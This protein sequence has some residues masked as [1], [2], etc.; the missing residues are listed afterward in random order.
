MAAL[1][2]IT[3]V[4]TTSNTRIEQGTYGATVSAGQPVYKDVAD[5]KWKLADSNDTAAKASVVGIAVTPGVDA[6]GAIIAKGGS[7]VLVGTTMTVGKPYYVGATAGS[8]VPE[9]DLTTGDY[10]SKVGT[11]SSATEMIIG[12]EATGVVK[13]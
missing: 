3:A 5:S 7:I 13:P 9:S 8:L 11:A 1:S 12:L 6:G 10:V 2:G 4:R